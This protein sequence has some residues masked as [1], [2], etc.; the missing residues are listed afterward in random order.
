PSSLQG[1]IATASSRDRVSLYAESGFWYDALAETIAGDASGD[2]QMT[3]LTDLA[4]LEAVEAG[5]AAD[6]EDS[7]A[8]PSDGHSGRLREVIEQLQ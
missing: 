2:L 7:E 4:N 6:S 8:A 1:A 3:L 5:P